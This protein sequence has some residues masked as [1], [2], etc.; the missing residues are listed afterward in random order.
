MAGQQQEAPG[1]QMPSERFRRPLMD[2]G[3]DATRQN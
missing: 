1:W 2:R 3:R